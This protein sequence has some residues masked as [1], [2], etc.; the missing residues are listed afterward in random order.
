MT[1]STT[2]E[3][4]KFSKRRG[5][6]L[7]VMKTPLT[8]LWWSLKTTR[9]GLTISIVLWTISSTWWLKED[10]KMKKPCETKRCLSS[11]M[12]PTRRIPSPRFKIR[13]ISLLLSKPKESNLFSSKISSLWTLKTPRMRD[14]SFL[15]SKS[16][17]CL[18][19]TQR[20]MI[21]CSTTIR[22]NRIRMTMCKLT[23]TSLSLASNS[24]IKTSGTW[25]GRSSP[26]M[27]TLGLKPTLSLTG[28]KG[29]S[30]SL[31][32]PGKEAAPIISIARIFSERNLCN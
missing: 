9:E 15:C 25:R 14:F 31:K 17:P 29:A 23:K 16:L 11:S 4:S 22:L 27:G 1:K 26:I 32:M 13:M 24:A 28:G 8:K 3:G 7:K 19:K 6:F 20:K 5:K 2:R 12:Q 30:G 18:A 10:P 21:F